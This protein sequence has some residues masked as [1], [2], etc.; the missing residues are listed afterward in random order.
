MR[1]LFAISL[2][3]ASL[4][5]AP[6]ALATAPGTS[7]IN[8]SYK[9]RSGQNLVTTFDIA[10]K[11]IQTFTTNVQRFCSDGTS[12]YSRIVATG[13]SGQPDA[14]LRRGLKGT[15]KIDLTVTTSTGPTARVRGTLRK[16]W[17][18]GTVVFSDVAALPIGPG[19]GGA[20]NT[21]PGAGATCSTNQATA[22]NRITFTSPW[23]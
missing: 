19:D 2:A 16:G 23:G 13:L 12:S 10:Q 18:T 21:P 7:P 22:S 20:P 14:A 4:V 8:G 3:M 1:L 6:S 5:A 11:R 17:I 15:W 9:G